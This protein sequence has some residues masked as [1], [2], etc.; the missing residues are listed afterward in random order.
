MDASW[1]IGAIMVMGMLVALSCEPRS[2]IPTGVNSVMI[3][4]ILSGTNAKICGS[5][6][7]RQARKLSEFGFSQVLESSQPESYYCLVSR[8]DLLIFEPSSSK[9]FSNPNLSGLFLIFTSR[10]SK[11]REALLQCRAQL[12]KEPPR[13]QPHLTMSSIPW[14]TTFWR[15]G[16]TLSPSRPCRALAKDNRNLPSYACHLG[17]RTP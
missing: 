14:T 16:F 8:D 10:N 17:P 9:P 6:S 5:N 3:P 4:A 2:A 15:C 12:H 11:A 1:T 13:F 7:R